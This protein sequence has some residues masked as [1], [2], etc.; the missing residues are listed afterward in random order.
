MAA[1]TNSRH[2]A[3][4]L[5]VAPFVFNCQEPVGVVVIGFSGERVA[6]LRLRWGVNAVG[7][8]HSSRPYASPRSEH[9]DGGFFAFQT[10]REFGGARVTALDDRGNPVA[11]EQ[12]AFSLAD[13]PPSPTVARPDA[14]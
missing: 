13:C 1:C 14:R 9:F 4:P 5:L 6:R 12:V 3:R 11:R 8:A 10:Q 2:R 7:Q